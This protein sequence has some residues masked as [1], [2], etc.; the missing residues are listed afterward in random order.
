MI[1]AM[2]E[3]LTATSN[4]VSNFFSFTS[5]L[6]GLAFLVMVWTTRDYKY[7]FR[8]NM[9]WLSGEKMFFIVFLIG[10]LTLT[11]DFIIAQNC[12]FPHAPVSQHVW[13]FLLAST[14]L[15]LVGYW[16]YV[17]FLSSPKYNRRNCLKFGR[18]FVWA[19]ECGRD[20]IM[21]GVIDF[22]GRSIR[23]IVNAAPAF[24]DNEREL[25]KEEG[26]ALEIFRVMGNDYFCKILVRYNPDVAIDLF[27]EITRQKKYDLGL[28]AFAR[29][30]ITQA[31]LC[32]NSFIYLETN[33]Y[34][35]ALSWHK[36]FSSTIYSNVILIRKLPE[37][38]EPLY[39]LTSQWTHEQA[40]AYTEVLLVA[41]RAALKKGCS[42]PFLYHR[43][44]EILED[45]ARRIGYLNG[46]E[47]SINDDENYLV[48]GAVAHFYE[49][50]VQ[51]IAKADE[52]RS[53]HRKYEERLEAKDLLDIIA[54]SIV[55]LFFASSRVRSPQ[56]S[57]HWIL[58][59]CE[60]MLGDEWKSASHK[61]LIRKIGGSLRK[62][63]KENAGVCGVNTLIFCLECF[64]F[65]RIDPLSGDV[66]LLNRFVIAYAKRHLLEM[67]KPVSAMKTF[68]FPDGVVIDL[69]RKRL[70]KTARDAIYGKVYESTLDLDG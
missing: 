65:T 8:L 67:Y 7:Q 4:D 57:R 24:V 60:H 51:A 58:I 48:H 61:L 63:F 6:T 43:Y 40:R 68:G 12:P 35:G 9:S 46:R 56:S 32:E 55:E 52:I 66:R 21:Q 31:L 59:R 18:G 36:P 27:G 42:K 10:A 19:I 69:E 20:E 37:L 14:F 41:L 50:L 23:E 64:G 54:D 15:A 38:L 29:H 44:F 30:F 53:T 17:S 62:T 2:V 26:V 16:V 22:F 11:S 33:A 45:S 70:I 49:Q 25:F 39:S 34:N 3:W 5:F 28:N 13:Q 1:E 47:E